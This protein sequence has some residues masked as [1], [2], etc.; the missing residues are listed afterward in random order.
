M[1]DLSVGD[2][3]RVCWQGVS[4]KPIATDSTIAEVSAD[5]LVV[6]VLVDVPRRIAF[7]RTTGRQI[8]GDGGEYW[9]EMPF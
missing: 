1:F 4:G 6:V 2:Q 9:L 7:S 8:H 3:V 5:T